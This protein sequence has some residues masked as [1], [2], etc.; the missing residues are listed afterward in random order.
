MF[1]GS[2]KHSVRWAEDTTGGRD[3][4]EETAVICVVDRI[5]TYTNINLCIFEKRAS[6]AL[7]IKQISARPVARCC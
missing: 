4:R 6:H 7:L 1:C 2:E 3:Q 5:L